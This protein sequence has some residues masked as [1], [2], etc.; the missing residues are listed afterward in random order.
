MPD[1]KK[2]S[3]L[4]TPSME[5]QDPEARG[6]RAARPSDI[7]RPG[8]RDILLRVKGEISKD[9]MSLVAAGVA[10]YALMALFPALAAGVGIYGLISDPHQ[11]QQQVQLLQ[12]VIP[13]DALNL[14]QRQLSSLASASGGALSLGVIGGLLLSLWS[15]TSGVKELIFAL[16]IA[17]D[18]PEKRGFLK[19]NALALALTLGAIV[20]TLLALALV[21]ALPALLGMLG[22]GEMTRG[23]VAWLRWPL[24]AAAVIF[25]LAVLYRVGPSRDRP[26]WRWV[27]WGSVIATVLWLTGSALFSFYVSN[28]GSYNE[29]YGSVGAVVVMLLWFYISAFVILLAAQI[30]AE[31]EHQTE[32]DTTE[33]Q[34]RPM[35][36]RGA[37][38]SDTLGPKP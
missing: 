26:E 5:T 9:H 32:Y 16:N 10:Y 6:R 27:S 25:A 36:E 35:G 1:P 13:Q 24:L 3:P 23:L 18:E 34:K 33:G 19:L 31:M 14:I 28:F 30:N 12:G 38:V 37:H 8:W 4:F 7:P 2:A 22:L 29:T 17:Y 20:F 11:I 21:V 15:A